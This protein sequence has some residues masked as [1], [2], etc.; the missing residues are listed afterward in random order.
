VI[1]QQNVLIL[2]KFGTL[3]QST[4]ASKPFFSKRKMDANFAST[5]RKMDAIAST[6]SGRSAV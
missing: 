6:N 2:L 1:L 4:S 5:K 3:T